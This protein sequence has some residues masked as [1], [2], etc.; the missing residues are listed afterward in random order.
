M[1]YD[2]GMKNATT[3]LDDTMTAMAQ[4]ILFMQQSIEFIKFQ[5]DQLKAKLIAEMALCEAKTLDVNGFG[6]ITAVE[7]SNYSKL[8]VKAASALLMALNQ[9]LPMSPVS[10]KASLRVSLNK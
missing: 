8:D 5:Q 2:R 7:P 1:R 3:P 6:S 4:Q 10:V 9:P